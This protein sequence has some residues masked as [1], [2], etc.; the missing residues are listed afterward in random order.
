MVSA[1]VARAMDGAA[2][3]RPAKRFGFENGAKNREGGNEDA[4]YEE[5][6]KQLREHERWPLCRRACIV[7]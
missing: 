7:Q 1:S 6:K 2:P 3:K 4:A 5:S